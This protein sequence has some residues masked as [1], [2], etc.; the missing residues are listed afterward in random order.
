[1]ILQGLFDPPV[2]KGFFPPKKTGGLCIKLWPGQSVVTEQGP[3]KHFLHC[4]PLQK[5]IVGLLLVCN[6]MLKYWP[7]TSTETPCQK[8]THFL[9]FIWRH[10]YNNLQ[11]PNKIK[12]NTH[13]H[14][15]KWWNHVA[16]PGRQLT[17]K[18]WHL[19]DSADPG[20]GGT[21]V[22]T[23]RG[24]SPSPPAPPPPPPPPS[25]WGWWDWGA[26]PGR[27]GGAWAAHGPA[28]WQGCGWCWPCPSWQCPASTWRPSSPHPPLSPCGVNKQVSITYMSYKQVAVSF[29]IQRYSIL[30]LFQDSHLEIYSVFT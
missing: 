12:P 1:M 11:Q 15:E 27:R 29:Q 10:V 7:V 8:N 23:V 18:W 6:H 2:H 14:P 4:V 13:M 28:W 22:R 25:P 19:V 30:K 5:V 26:A 9:S 17:I 21:H 3:Q 16:P 20:P 24:R